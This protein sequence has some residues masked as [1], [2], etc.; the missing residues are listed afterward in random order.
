MTHPLMASSVAPEIS[1]SGVALDSGRPANVTLHTGDAAVSRL[2]DEGFAAEWEL[3]ASRCPWATTYQR[4]PFVHAWLSVFADRVALVVVEGRSQQ[5]ELCG[6]LLLARDRTSGALAHVGTFHAE[7]QTWLALPEG[8]DLFIIGALRA[9]ADRNL[10]ASLRLHFLAPGT[11]LGWIAEYEG[12]LA[13]RVFLNAHR[14]G[15]H[16]L[17]ADHVRA[18][19]QKRSNRSKLRRLERGGS[20]RLL[21]ITTAAELEEWLPTIAAHC[22]ARQGAIN[23]VM[24]FRDEP[25]KAAFYRALLQTPHLA[26][27]VVLVSGNELLACHIGMRD[28]AGSVML[29]L[30]THA[31]QHGLNSPGKL[32]LLSLF[33]RLALQGFERFDLTP[34]GAYKERFATSF[35]E[36]FSLDIC[37]T[38]AAAASKGLERT[39]RKVGRRLLAMRQES[40]PMRE[41]VPTTRG[42]V[43]ARREGAVDDALARQCDA[44]VELAESEGWDVRVNCVA[45]LLA[46]GGNGVA[47]AELLRFLAAATP[48]LEHGATV[49]TVTRHGHLQL[50]AW[51]E[52]EGTAHTL[53][54]GEAGDILEASSTVATLR[55]PAVNLTLERLTTPQQ[56][57]ALPTRAAVAALLRECRLRYEGVTT[58]TLRSAAVQ[59]ASLV[60]PLGF[61][62]DRH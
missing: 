48:R 62:V 60:D 42:P 57:G 56:A 6:L 4:A 43:I 5:G 40:S 8:G 19:L 44:V 52:P 3:L 2:R 32:L 59:D 37:L 18:S 29:G 24:P 1:G 34:G 15:L 30:I 10:A 46:F 27:A 21:E 41:A 39:G 50:C 25:R 11:P 38:A 35:D 7:Y 53:E 36:V 45:S 55:V 31:P 16:D 33:E 12:I 17:D 20:V 54:S 13:P 9:L 28:H 14:R 23:G 22:D 47:R 49:C 58:F 61:E 51:L 26:H